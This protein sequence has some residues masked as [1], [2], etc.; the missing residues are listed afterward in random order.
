MEAFQVSTHSKQRK[1]ARRKRRIQQRLAPRRWTAQDRPMFSAANIHYD[2]ADRTRA[3]GA[4]GI[5]AIHLLAQRTGLIEAIDRKLHLLKVHL[6]YHESDHV[7]NVG[8][9]LLAGGACLE[10][11]EL[12]R[13]DEAYLDALPPHGRA[14]TRIQRWSPNL[15]QPVKVDRRRDLKGPFRW[16]NDDS[17]RRS[18][19][20][21]SLWRR[22]AAS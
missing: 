4:G 18:S 2:V 14:S 17:S 9:N 5:G 8:Y 15:G 16:P 20:P 11:L 10:D 19:R 12:L 7:V 3:L 13:E 1:S 21:R 22:S 6:P